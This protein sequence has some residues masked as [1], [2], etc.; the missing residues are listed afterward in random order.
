[1]NERTVKRHR[2][3]RTVHEAVEAMQSKQQTG[4]NENEVKSQW[5]TFEIKNYECGDGKSRKRSQMKITTALWGEHK[6]LKD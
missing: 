6:V 1:M 5:N 3:M 2:R 4:N